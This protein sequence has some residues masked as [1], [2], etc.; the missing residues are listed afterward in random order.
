[1]PTSVRE[2]VCADPFGVEWTVKFLWHQVGI[3]I[4]HADTI[5]CKF[6][7]SS[8]TGVTDKVIAIEHVH[9]RDLAEE[10]NREITDPWVMHLAGAHLRHMIESG[11]DLDKTLVTMAMDDL[12]R[13]L[14]A[15]AA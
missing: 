6:H 4:R 1:M 7:L 13:A 9:L 11:E 2:F 14:G 8:S 3:A 12:R 15:I 10:L 5:D